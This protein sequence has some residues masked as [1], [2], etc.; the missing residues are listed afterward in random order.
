[1]DFFPFRGLGKD[2]LFP[3]VSPFLFP[4]LLRDARAAFPGSGFPPPLPLL[5][6]RPV[7]FFLDWLLFFFPFP[8]APKLLPFFLPEA[9]SFSWKELDSVFFPLVRHMRF[10]VQDSCLDVVAVSLS[11]VGAR[12]AVGVFWPDGSRGSSPFACASGRVWALPSRWGTAF[13]KRSPPFND[14]HEFPLFSG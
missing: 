3:P 4:P 8:C 9:F 6:G 7:L 11:S 5:V 13:L 10:Y 14:D 12:A 2:G 1:M